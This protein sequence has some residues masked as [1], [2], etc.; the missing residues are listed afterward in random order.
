MLPEV[1]HCLLKPI[2]SSERLGGMFAWAYRM[3]PPLLLLFFNSGGARADGRVL[4]LVHV[5][6]VDLG[7]VLI[8]MLTNAFGSVS[9]PDMYIRGLS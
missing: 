5:L 8:V 4:G 6:A 2:S 1:R 7:L 9:L 3:V